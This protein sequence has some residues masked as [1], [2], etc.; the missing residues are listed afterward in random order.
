M[1]NDWKQGMS[2]GEYA[3]FVRFA[4]PHQA[5]EV[6]I[7]GIVERLS[8]AEGSSGG[9]IS[10]G[11]YYDHYGEYPLSWRF[12]PQDYH[13]YPEVRES[14]MANVFKRFVYAVR[15]HEWMMPQ[16]IDSGATVRLWSDHMPELLTSIGLPDFVD[17]A[18]NRGYR[19][20]KFCPT[21]QARVYN[22]IASGI[23]L[24]THAIGTY[25]DHAEL[26]SYESMF[27]DGN[28]DDPFC[29]RSS[30]SWA[31]RIG[32]I[33]HHEFFSSYRDNNDYRKRVNLKRPLSV[34]VVN[35]GGRTLHFSAVFSGDFWTTS[36]PYDYSIDWST[37]VSHKL[38]TD[39]LRGII[40]AGGSMTFPLSGYYTSGKTP[41]NLLPSA[42][43]QCVSGD[44]YGS[45]GWE[46]HG[47]FVCSGMSGYVGSERFYTAVEIGE[48]C[49]FF[50]AEGQNLSEV[51]P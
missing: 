43:N 41:Q 8:L 35:S 4:D 3:N 17:P 22:G 25:N 45:G 31:G 36:R 16:D 38:G 2:L 20:P 37:P 32:Y 7:A 24:L 50:E 12:P 13:H 28:D 11:Y 47:G 40:S 9:Y 44:A 19:I 18:S 23:S 5:A 10:S 15:E 21:N 26:V 30:S 27:A 49:R 33:Y 51:E 14:P 29:I 6:L 48:A 46:P 39:D 34:T 1:S 42:S